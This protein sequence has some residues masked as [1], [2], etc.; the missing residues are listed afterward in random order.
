M[1]LRT[2]LSRA[3]PS[4]AS[5]SEDDGPTD[6]EQYAATITTAIH[7]AT[8]RPAGALEAREIRGWWERQIPADL[9]AGVVREIVTPE[10]HR[11]CAYVRKEIEA[12]IRTLALRSAEEPPALREPPEAID[13][14]TWV[15]VR[16]QLRRELGDDW[17]QYLEPLVP[18]GETDGRLRLCAPSDGFLGVVAPM[19]EPVAAAHGVVVEWSTWQ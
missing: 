15:R 8:G 2:V 16:G 17:R 10:I 5:L 19:V 14:P 13:S 9:V 3:V 12:R 4:R 6:A 1:S 18:R 7:D 11:P